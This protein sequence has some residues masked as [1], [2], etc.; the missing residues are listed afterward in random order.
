MRLIN[1]KEE[2]I[3]NI[4]TLEDYIKEVKNLEVMDAISLI[5]RGT[6]FVAYKFDLHYILHQVDSLGTEITNLMNIWLLKIKMAEKLI[7]QS[8]KF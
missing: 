7:K 8:L 4:E 5:K 2:L 3:K 6:C 1:S